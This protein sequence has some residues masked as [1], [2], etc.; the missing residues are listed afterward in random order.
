MSD[1]MVVALER[2]PNLANRALVMLMQ[3]PANAAK[4]EEWIRQNAEVD[5]RFERLAKLAGIAIDNKGE[6][7]EIPRAGCGAV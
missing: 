3:D 7:I 1:R 4:V 2:F 6:W 5:V